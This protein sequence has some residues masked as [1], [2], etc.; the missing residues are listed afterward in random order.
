MRAIV[1]NTYGS[2]DVLELQE[3]DKPDVADDQVLVR[4]RA[5]SVNPADWYS[6][7]GVPYVA[8][9]Q[10]GLRKPK[11][12]RTGVDFAGTVEA[13]GRNV[14]EFRPGDEVFGGRD[15]AF[16]EYVCVRED[17]AVV[18]KPANVTFEE[19][20]A[21]PVAALTALQGLRDKGQLQPGQKVLINGASGGVGTFAV[22]IAKALGAEVTGVC[23]TRNVDIVRSLG[24]DHVVDYTREDFTPSDQRY[25]LMFDVAGSRSWSECGRVFN[26]QATL[27]IVG[28]P[29]GNRL[30][31]PLSHIIKVR[32]ASLR[33]SQ[34]AVFFIAKFNKADMLAL[35]DL[36]EAGKV[37]PVIDRSYGLSEIADAFKYL[38]EGHA[39]GKIVVTV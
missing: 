37:T 31:G 35:R 27:V 11:S 13:V 20:A 24:A 1:R 2:P 8:R 4:V 39:R 14:T 12:N 3:I 32:L 10:M 16:A 30:M 36:L 22:Q 25:D 34:K 15:G 19:A 17:R 21:V 29:K 28:A 9:P 38:G 33:G 26:R 23:S 5:A 18:P 6:M 7:T